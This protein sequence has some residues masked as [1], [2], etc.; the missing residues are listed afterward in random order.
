MCIFHDCTIPDGN[1]LSKIA[2][3]LKLDNPLGIILVYWD[4]VQDSQYLCSVF[5]KIDSAL[6]IEEAI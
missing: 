3:M 6:E 5:R 4:L 2:D 1:V